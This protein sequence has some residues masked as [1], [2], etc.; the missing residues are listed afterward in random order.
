MRPHA[1]ITGASTGIGRELA[2]CFAADHH[3]LV[4]VSRNEERLQAL[5]RELQEVQNLDIEVIPWDLST[6]EAAAELFAEVQR[7]Q[8]AVQ[9]LVNNAG[10]GNF[11]EVRSLEVGKD[12]E[13]LQLNVISLTGL[14]ERFLPEMLARGAGKILNVA[15]T[16]AF[17]PIPQMA[18]YAASKAYVLSY[19]E[20]LAEELRGS[21]VTVS[22]LCPGPTATEFGKRAGVEMQALFEGPLVMTAKEVARQGYVGMKAGQTVIV[23]GPLN[24]VGVC[25]T[26]WVPRFLTRRI[27][28]ELM[29]TVKKRKGR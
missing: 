28:G 10:F 21:G 7:R 3:P 29:R 23:T 8:I 13:M 14:T 19:S 17:Q 5:R 4:L 12:E 2:Y 9:Y 27:A 25:S 22:V 20:A 15:S 16:A 24:Q 1:L 18:A 6:P 26:R 11:G